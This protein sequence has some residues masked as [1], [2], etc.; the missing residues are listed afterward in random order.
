MVICRRA[1]P[2]LVGFVL[3]WLLAA[4][5]VFAAPVEWSASSG[6]N[7]HWYEAVP[8]SGISWATAQ[9]NAVSEDGYLATANTSE[10]NDFIYSLVKD[11]PEF[12]VMDPSNNALGP[13]LGGYQLDGSPEPGGGWMWVDGNPVTYTNWGS[14]GEPNN[15]LGTE[16]R[17]MLFGVGRPSGPEWND[18]PRSGTFPDRGSVT[19]YIIEYNTAPEP[20][21]AAGGCALSFDGI[22]QYAIIGPV[23]EFDVDDVTVEAW[24][25]CTSLPSDYG[26]FVWNGDDR[27]GR[28]PFS[29]CMLPDGR[30]S[31]ATYWDTGAAVVESDSPLSLDVWHHV[32]WVVSGTQ[33]IAWLMVDG[34]RQTATASIPSGPA[35]G[36]SFMAFG[37][38]S[39]SYPPVPGHLFAGDLDEVRVWGLSRT[40]QDIVRDMYRPL[41]G[42]E[43]GLLAY[44]SFDECQGQIAHDL[45]PHGKHATLGQDF[46]A[47][48]VDPTWVTPGAPLL[49]GVPS[50]AITFSPASPPP[51]ETVSFDS[52]AA[53]PDGAIVSA[54]WSFGD[55]ATATGLI[56][57]HTYDDNGTYTVTCTVTD[58]DGLSA[59]CSAS[60]TVVMPTTIKLPV[61]GWYIIAQPHQGNHALSVVRVRRMDS[62]EELSYCDAW[63]AGWVQPYLYWYD[64]NDPGY[65]TA[66]CDLM[67]DDDTLRQSRGYWLNTNIAGLE[68][69][70]P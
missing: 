30:V 9:A 39:G 13:W 69:V 58:N 25:R 32:S 38:L 62:G 27:P 70:F 23:P 19:G 5:C 40:E 14:N 11:R 48:S 18:F 4:P 60:L 17:I 65:K 56:T 3:S 53:D 42:N 44:W 29:L 10:E 51:D 67:P 43:P 24:F 33:H 55:G 28:D 66:G 16:D 59:T 41:Q 26:F 46:T 21:P 45:G 50:C 57:T 31:A 12:W 22:Q 34:T 20:P 64:P 2:L 7:G 6:G 8:V 68:L 47:E 61:I 15:S 54:A 52:N 63:L 49:T 37:T 35:K 1:I 36:T